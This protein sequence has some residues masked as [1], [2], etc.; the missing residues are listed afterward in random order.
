MTE[1]VEPPPGHVFFDTSNAGINTPDERR[2]ENIQQ[3]IR[4]QLPQTKP[5]APNP[6]LE[7]I[8]ACGGPSL[9]THLKTIRRLY[10]RGC[11]LVTVNATH[12]FMIERG[13]IPFAHVMMDARPFNARFV[14]SPHPDVRYFIA[15]QCDPSVFDNLNGSKVGI[16]HLGDVTGE[17]D[18]LDEYYGEKR[19]ILVG[20]G[21]TIA[22]R[23]IV[24]LINLGVSKFHIIG[25]DSCYLGGKHH[26]YDQPENDER[27][28]L[29]HVAGR[30][31]RCSPWMVRQ[32][33]D[34]LKMMVNLG[35]KFR[36][37]VYG[38]GL[39]AHVM[40]TGAQLEEVKETSDG[41][42]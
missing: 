1:K 37:R 39:I 29:F 12:D 27:S 19:Y 15:S 41:T 11:K 25:L 5:Y 7:V 13:F 26:S 24:L 18:I 22:T 34:W 14:S 28:G 30:H 21:T 42:R 6:N 32:H 3:N 36:C 35:D 23:A 20:G 8:L 17:V 16:V 40:R 38:K 2:I 10:D 4:R 33:D 9:K 31:F